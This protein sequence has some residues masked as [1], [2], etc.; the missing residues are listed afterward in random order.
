MFF[1]TIQLEKE[2]IDPGGVSTKSREKNRRLKTQS[3]GNTR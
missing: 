2:R 3:N 1:Q